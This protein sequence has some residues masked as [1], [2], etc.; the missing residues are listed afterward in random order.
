MIDDYMLTDLS[1]YRVLRDASRLLQA[2]T[3]K[4]SSRVEER[5]VILI[6]AAEAH[7]Q[8]SMCQVSLVRKDLAEF[9]YANGYYGDALAQYRLAL[10]INP[11]L[12]V[13]RRLK[14][15]E[16]MEDIA[17]P[18]CSPYLVGDILQFEEYKDFTHGYDKIRT[19]RVHQDDLL[20]DPTWEAEIE[21]R[22]DA[23]GPT[24]KSEF[25]RLREA[26]A[27]MGGDLTLSRR[28]EDELT[29]KAMERSFAPV[30]PNL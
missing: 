28:E 17:P 20:Y 8:M 16:A 19:R 11:R 9:Y 10:E 4:F 12:P 30:P 2:L 1:P 29:L 25:H 27:K 21:T 26:R 24:A 5:V 3:K 22:L 14:E 6:N 18:T 7:P 13:K 23:L 15:L